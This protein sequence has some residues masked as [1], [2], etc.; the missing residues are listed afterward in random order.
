MVVIRII[1]FLTN[2]G[3]SGFSCIFEY[4]VAVAIYNSREKCL[5]YAWVLNDIHKLLNIIIAFSLMHAYTH[6]IVA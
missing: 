6:K 5:Y 4:C 2:S 3:Y 1:K